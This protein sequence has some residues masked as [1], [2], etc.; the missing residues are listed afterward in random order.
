MYQAESKHHHFLQALA[1]S[2]SVLDE[3]IDFLIAK[4]DDYK[5]KLQR[6]AHVYR[7]LFNYC[8]SYLFQNNFPKEGKPY[9]GAA[10]G[11]REAFGHYRFRN[12]ND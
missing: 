2:G 12:R 10:K 11:L 3:M 4:R 5:D 6:S 7:A 9:E 1:S 8:K